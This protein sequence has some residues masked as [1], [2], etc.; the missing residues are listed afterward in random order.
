MGVGIIV[1]DNK[2][3]VHASSSKTILSVRE[4]VV[5]EAMGALFDAEFSRDLG[6]QDIDV[7]GDSLQVIQAISSYNE[8]NGCWNN[9]EG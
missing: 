8:N 1:K 9:C 3:Q 6:I 2:D 7:E 5:A 4:P